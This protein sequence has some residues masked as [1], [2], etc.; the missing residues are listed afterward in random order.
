MSTE[1]SPVQKRKTLPPSHILV[2]DDEP[3][4][5]DMASTMLKR[6]GCTV[7]VA[8]NGREALNI[9]TQKKDK[10]HIVILDMI[11]PILDGKE[12]FLELQKINPDLKVLLAS[13]FSLDA[14]AQILLSQGVSG[15]LQ[16]PFRMHE[17]YNKLADIL[18]PEP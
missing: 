16:K 9:Y 11:M 15:F 8:E 13:G 2:V 3:I 12:T 6:L 1:Q 17:L 18:E 5:L 14:E 7:D 10:I 4:L